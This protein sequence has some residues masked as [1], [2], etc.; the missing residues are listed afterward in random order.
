MAATAVEQWKWSHYPLKST[1]VL[2]LILKDV[3]P[4]PN[5]FQS[6]L[7]SLLFRAEQK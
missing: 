6:L 3:E 5:T 2:S 4:D 1:G 7:V